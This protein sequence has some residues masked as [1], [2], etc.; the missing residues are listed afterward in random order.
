[1]PLQTGITYTTSSSAVAKRPRVASY[2]SLVSFIA[3]IVQY[4]Q[5]SFL[6]L[7]STSNLPVSTIDSVL[8]S[9]SSLAVIHTIHG[10]PWMCIARDR[11]LSVSR[12]TQP[13]TTVTVSARRAW[14]TNT[15][16][17][18]KAGRLVQNTNQGAAVIDRKANL[19][20]IE[21]LAYPT[22]IWGNR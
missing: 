9:T 2:L 11:A 17:K 20:R 21:I 15:R 3:S 22:C 8:L 14:S 18:Q 5:R 1:M 19:L 6:L 10:R 12:C 13:R 16:S 4:L 7:T